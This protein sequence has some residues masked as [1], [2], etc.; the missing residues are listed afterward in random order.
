MDRD[1]MDGAFGA[2]GR[3]LVVHTA[4][5]RA[6]RSQI[7]SCAECQPDVPGI[8]VEAMLDAITGSESASTR[9]FFSDWI[10]CP[11]CGR[12]IGESAAVQAVGPEFI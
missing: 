1:R 11:G 9:Y 3:I 2:T 12:K 5:L 4:T 7:A 10:A 8:V 6:L